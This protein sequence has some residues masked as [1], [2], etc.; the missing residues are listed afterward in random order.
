MG[1]IRLR[2]VCTAFL[3]NGDDY[4]LMKRSA[5]RKI[6]PGF[7]YGVGGHVEPAEI[8]DPHAA[9]LREIIEETGFSEEDILDLCHR[10]IVMRRGG[11]EIV[12]NHFFFGHTRTREFSESDEGRLFW[13]PADKVLDH[14]FFDAIRL[15]LERYFEEGD[16]TNEVAVGIVHGEP[17]AFIHWT[18]IHNMEPGGR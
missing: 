3:R 7:W 4:L 15:T 11:D 18:P 10:Y 13:V 12:V 9:C 6:G 2:T 14:S 1:L 8:N 16:R 5:N 17:D